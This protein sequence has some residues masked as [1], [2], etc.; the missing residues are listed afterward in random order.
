VPGARGRRAEMTVYRRSRQ[1]SSWSKG[2]AMPGKLRIAGAKL[3]CR[4]VQK[5]QEESTALKDTSLGDQSEI[6]ADEELAA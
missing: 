5:H 6:S 2:R 3:G 4:P 1:R